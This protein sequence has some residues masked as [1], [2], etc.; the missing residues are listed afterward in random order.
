MPQIKSAKKRVIVSATKTLRNK[1][2]K[3]NLKTVLKQ[4]NAAIEA[5]AEN[6]EELVR[7]A[8]KRI[9]QAAAKGIMHKNTAAH[10]KSELALKLN[11][12]NK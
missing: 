5:N 8:I 11:A 4:A 6:K 12:S 7:F 1:A 2:I 9:D 10:K 3:S